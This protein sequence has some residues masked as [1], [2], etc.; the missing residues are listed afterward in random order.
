MIDTDSTI[1]IRPAPARSSRPLL[2]GAAALVAAAAGGGAAWWL[3]RP[4]PAPPGIAVPAVPPPM[5]ETQRPTEAVPP[6][7]ALLPT[8]LPRPPAPALE[9]ATPRRTFREILAQQADE[10]VLVRLAENPRVFV[11]DFPTLA[12]QAAALNRVA[13]LIEK[14]HAP[15]DRVLTEAELGRL[16]AEGS[17]PADQYY[18]GHNYRGEDLARFFALL[19][20][21]GLPRRPEEARVEAWLAEM[22]RQVP[23]G[24]VALITIPRAG[25]VVDGPARAAILQHEIAHGFY[26]VDPLF[27]GYVRRT[28]S[29]RF[30]PAVR[31]AFRRFL[32]GEGY[33]VTNEDMVINESMAYLL[34]TPDPRF[35]SPSMVG[36]DAEA[37]EGLRAL[38]RPGVPEALRP[39]MVPPPAVTPA[40]AQ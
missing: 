26:F 23:D 12:A 22:R 29:E 32:A 38:L 20:R 18:L 2:L 8:A 34:F 9:A 35:F 1:R 25:G 39:L 17:Q 3:L 24:E 15:R 10:P 31:E 30:P 36:L 28:W 40:A 5:P 33:D 16:I 11:A 27:A 7:P 4:A 19:T 21:Q 13:A 6:P 14:A 37:V